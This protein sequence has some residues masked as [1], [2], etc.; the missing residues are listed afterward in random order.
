[1][2]RVY[3]AV[4]LITALLVGG[5]VWYVMHLRSENKA[6][7]E[8]NTALSA[9]ND[10]LLLEQS[11]ERGAAVAHTKITQ[12]VQA[13]AKDAHAKLYEA[14][15]AAPDW[16]SGTVPDAVLDALGVPQRTSAGRT[17]PATS[18]VPDTNP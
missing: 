5:G 18:A 2:W 9:A 8:A 6:L 16:A 11:A 4:G 12:A 15:T 3:A 1:M 17:V 10:A 13:V 7:G 14:A